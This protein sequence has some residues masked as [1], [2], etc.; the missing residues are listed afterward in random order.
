VDALVAKDRAIKLLRSSINKATPR[1]TN[2]AT[3]LVAIVFFVNL[4]LIDSGRGGW[5]AHIEAANA[6]ISSLHQAGRILDSTIAPLADV[7]AADCLTYRILGSTISGD[8]AVAGSMHDRID[9][10]T[11]LQRAEAHSYHCY[12]PLFLHIILSTSRLCGHKPVLLSGETSAIEIET[13]SSLLS[14]AYSF[15]IREWVYS[16]R[17]LSDEDDLEARVNMASVHRAAACLYILL[18]VPE[19]GNELPSQPVLEDIVL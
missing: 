11:V 17:G 19:A 1:T 9:V 10:L 4:D 16:I 6:L 12:P 2:Q 7:I 8:G 13:A 5:K 15:N 18:A 14:Q 3:V